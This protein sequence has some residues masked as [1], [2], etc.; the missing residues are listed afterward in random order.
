MAGHGKEII[1]IDEITAVAS[2]GELGIL[3]ETCKN[4]SS[5]LIAVFANGYTTLNTD[6]ILVTG[7]QHQVLCI[8]QAQELLREMK[9]KTYQDTIDLSNYIEKIVA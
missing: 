8:P 7:Q 6:S 5:Q 1:A 3:L 9:E 2:K 4:K